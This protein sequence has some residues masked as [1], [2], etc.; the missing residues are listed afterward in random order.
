MPY[1]QLPVPGQAQAMGQAAPM[2]GPMPGQAQGMMGQPAP[3][4]GALGPVGPQSTP[5]MGPMGGAPMGAPGQLQLGQIAGLGPV[6]GAP[7]GAPGP[8]GG[9]MSGGGMPRGPVALGGAMS[10]G[11]MPAGPAGGAY[12]SAPRMNPG[13]M[14]PGGAPPMNQQ[15]NSFAQQQLG[16]QGAMGGGMQSGMPGPAGPGDYGSAPRMPPAAAGP[17][18]QMMLAQQLRQDAGAGPRV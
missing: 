5:G 15:A 12:S 14:A 18:R 3:M 8:M 17:N 16:I 4:K 7:M 10:G 9:A 1:P 13:G 6:G 2:K 11:G